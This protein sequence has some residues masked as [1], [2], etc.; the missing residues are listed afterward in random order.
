MTNKTKRFI[1]ATGGRLF[2]QLLPARIAL[3]AVAL[4]LLVMLKLPLNSALAQTA[5]A[6]LVNKLQP[7]GLTHDAPVAEAFI[8]FGIDLGPFWSRRSN[9]AEAG[10]DSGGFHPFRR[11]R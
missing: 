10:K 3:G 4:G 1:T 2:I 6:P 7:F 8:I 5:N 11:G 9:S